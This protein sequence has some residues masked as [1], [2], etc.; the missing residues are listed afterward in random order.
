MLK[1]LLDV[2]Y[3]PA[4]IAC[5]RVLPGPGAF[6]CES[7]DTAVERLPPACCR[8]CAEPGTFPGATCPRCRASPPPFS[9]AWAPFA[10]EGPVSRAIHRFKYE[11]R[12]ELAAPLGELLAAEARSFLTHAPTLVVA[13][14]LHTR[15]YRARKYD[16]AQLLAG[17]LAKHLGHEAPVGWLTRTRETQR[18]VG[19]SE[20]ARA[21]NVDGA[22]RAT[23]DVA[24]RDVLLLDD[25]F[26]TGATARAAATALSAAGASRVEVLTLARAFTLT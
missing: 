6:F 25:V 1:A 14:P 16:Q 21:D 26:T 12:P 17:A 23:T 11:D 7:C 10:H 3:P 22:F 4:C 9:R 13:L 18:Q 8:T 19:L 20:E 5:A 15:R 2:L 24:D